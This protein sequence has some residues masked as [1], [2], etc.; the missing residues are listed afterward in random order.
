MSRRA[1]PGNA[2]KAE[3]NLAGIA[4]SPFFG[5]WPTSRIAGP[6]KGGPGT[7]RW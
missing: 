1:P 5:D 3:L 7:E 4:D 2:V 6:C